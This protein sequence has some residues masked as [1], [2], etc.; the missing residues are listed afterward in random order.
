MARRRR[1]REP[2]SSPRSR[3]EPR[4][5]EPAPGLFDPALD[6]ARIDRR[7]APLRVRQRQ[8]RLPPGQCLAL[9]PVFPL[10]ARL[11]DRDHAAVR[12]DDDR[13]AK[14]RR[15][16]KFSVLATSLRHRPGVSERDPLD[17]RSRQSRGRSAPQAWRAP[18]RG[19]IG[20]EVDDGAL[21]RP[22]IP[23]GLT[24]AP[25]RIDAPA[26][27]RTDIAAPKPLFRLILSSG[28][29]FALAMHLRAST[30]I[31][32]RRLHPVLGPTA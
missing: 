3:R 25:A 21:Q 2:G 12:L 9:A 7:A 23:S 19:L 26:A 31:P 32:L 29:F 30:N 22:R 24:F 17:S 15:F 16:R 10:A 6:S 14:T 28:V 18:A 20:G 11:D 1:P 27:S 8:L 4:R 13:S 5:K